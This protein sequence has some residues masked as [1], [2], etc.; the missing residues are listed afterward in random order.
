MY[1]MFNGSPI[2]ALATLSLLASPAALAQTAPAPSTP[3]KASEDTKT[4]TQLQN[5]K[6]FTAWGRNL[7][8]KGV[9]VA[10]LDAGIDP[11]H[12]DLNNGK[13][14]AMKRFDNP[15]LAV[16]ET[17]NGHGTAMASIIA[18]NYNNEGTV[19]IV[20]DAK[21]VFGQIGTGWSASP[22]KAG[23]AAQWAAD[24][25]AVVA[26]LSFSASFDSN[27]RKGLV[28][29][30]VEKGVYI[31][32]DPSRVSTAKTDLSFY[33]YA[34]LL[35]SYKAATDKGIILVMAAGNQSLPYAASPGMLATATDKEGKLLLSGRTIIVGGVTSTLTP[36]SGLNRAGH[37]CTNVA[38]TGGACLDLHRVKDFFIVA[39]GTATAAAALTGN[40]TQVLS[41]TSVATAYVTGSI[42]VLRQA[43]PQLRPEQTVQLLFRTAQDMGAP[44]VDE[45]WGWGMVDLDKATQPFGNLVANV[46]AAGSKA[47][48]SNTGVS[49]TLIAKT[50]SFFNESQFEDEFGRNFSVRLGDAV[51]Q[52]RKATSL[53]PYLGL[54]G[55][56]VRIAS[57]G[58]LTA[59]QSRDGMAFNISYRAFN[60]EL[61]A[62]GNRQ[63]V[64]GTSMRDYLGVNGSKNMWIGLG[65]TI[66]LGD[67]SAGVKGYLG[68][69]AVNN[70]AGSTVRFSNLLSV[71][72]S[73]Q[74]TKNGVLSEHD[75][76]TLRARPFN[77]VI[78]GYL[79]ATRVGSY[80]FS[81]DDSGGYYNATPNVET[82]RFKLG[83]FQA[84]QI[85]VSY[86]NQ[87]SKNAFIGLDYAFAASS[88]ST[89]ATLQARVAVAF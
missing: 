6:A 36:Q 15:M 21:I 12:V 24:Q 51:M 55:S 58:N 65:H 28:A 63:Q 10:V 9:I 62:S 82:Q 66:E 54:D 81:E 30:S 22:S 41:G 70:H 79:D 56:L 53:H 43:W 57:A 78:S 50:T 39:P 2:G 8:G 64:L 25:G 31:Q 48:T 69:T 71:S 20:Y 47:L 89:D 3:P 7:T 38:P 74:V 37:I 27:Y 46:T 76:F 35:P 11:T 88:L 86:Q 68:R 16:N 84:P 77:R 85:N 59:M 42:A 29:S 23:L 1:A 72:G 13:V 75:T 61:G 87:I 34:D 60:F 33:G 83:A 73:A 32:T 18:G 80:S 52:N 4:K 67:W 19:G 14:I 17:K 5:I 44:G 26:N 45:V 40:G 49:G